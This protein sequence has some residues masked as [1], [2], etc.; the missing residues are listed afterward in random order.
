[1]RVVF[2]AIGSALESLASL[3][4]SDPKSSQLAVVVVILLALLLSEVFF[5]TISNP[6]PVTGY[7]DGWV[8]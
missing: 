3:W 8:R 6:D 2:S 5:G 1:M 7:G 4:P